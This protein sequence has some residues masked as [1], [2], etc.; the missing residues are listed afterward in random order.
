MSDLTFT[1]IGSVT[2]ST[3]GN[4]I[5]IASVPSVEKG[6]AE[7]LC[8]YNTDGN[9]VSDTEGKLTYSKEREIFKIG[10]DAEFYS[11]AKFLNTTYSN[12]FIA[13]NVKIESLL[14]EKNSIFS[15]LVN[16]FHHTAVFNKKIRVG[17]KLNL[18]STTIVSSKGSPI[19]SLG[20]IAIDNAYLYY[21][22]ACYDGQT[23]I[24]VRWAIS[25]K[26]W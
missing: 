25:D 23:D 2:V 12:N 10:C 15:G 1:G 11:D 19:D 17:G 6:F 9:T 18:R 20:D 4:N 22:H 7:S 26:Q 5:I 14:V 21:C 16:I 13:A 3:L 24:W 8:Y